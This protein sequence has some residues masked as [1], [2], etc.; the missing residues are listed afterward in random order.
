[1][2]K[3]INNQTLLPTIVTVIT[4]IAIAVIGILIPTIIT[5]YKEPMPVNS[6][7]IMGEII[8]VNNDSIKVTYK[9]ENKRYN[10]E[11][12]EKS[13]LDKKGN[14][15]ELYVNNTDPETVMRADDITKPWT[16][17]FYAT[18]AGVIVLIISGIFIFKPFSKIP[19]RNGI[20]SILV[21]SE[22]VC[23]V[24]ALI[25]IFVLV[26]ST[27]DENKFFTVKGTIVE[28]NP[29]DKQI[30]PFT[31]IKYTYEDKEYQITSCYYKKSDYFNK[32]INLYV[33]KEDKNDIRRN[34]F[35]I[36]TIT[37]IYISVVIFI[38]GLIMLNTKIKR[39]KLRKRLYKEGNCVKAKVRA[40]KYDKQTKINGEYPQFAEVV[41]EMDDK[42]IVYVSETYTGLIKYSETKPIN[43][44]DLYIDKLDNENYAIIFDFQ[45][46]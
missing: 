6:V 38:L 3:K 37:L 31:I 42:K 2:E 15:I 40:L 46:K 33:N 32:N 19:V 34:D 14:A 21:F 16:I 24:M 12:E 43:E 30:K 18:L 35:D 9:V 27:V 8:E 17:K 22:Y 28:S 26:T 10:A 29:G 4:L 7:S 11:L 25:G 23:I 5:S 45:N 36:V 39:D 44:V 1:M 20:E 13:E 41:Y